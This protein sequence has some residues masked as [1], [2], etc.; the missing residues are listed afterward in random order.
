METRVYDSFS[1]SKED[2]YHGGPR[3]GSAE[4]TK[5]GLSQLLANAAHTLQGESFAEDIMLLC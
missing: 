5:S 1:E 2:S 3:N 4:P